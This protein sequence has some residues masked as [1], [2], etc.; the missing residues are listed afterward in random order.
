MDIWDGEHLSELALSCLADGQHEA[1]DP[2]ARVHAETCAA[3]ALRL[4]DMALEAHDVGAALRMARELPA[5]EAVWAFPKWLV[6]AATGVAVISGAP[7]MLEGFPRVVTWILAAPRIVPVITTT[8]AAISKTFSSTAVSALT[9]FTLVLIGWA[10]ARA[11][12]HQV[13]S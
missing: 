12:P 5:R 1:V 10:V 3:C 2:V 6:L 4:G 9:T 7:S 13:K 8:A 11:T